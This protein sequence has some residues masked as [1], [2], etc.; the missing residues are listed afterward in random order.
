MTLDQ[1]IDMFFIQSYLL[2]SSEEEI[3]ASI[4]SSKSFLYFL[5]RINKILDNE[6]YFLFFEQNQIIKI[7]RIIEQL[8]FVYSSAGYIRKYH[9]I[10]YHK[11]CAMSYNLKKNSDFIIPNVLT[12]EKALRG[13]PEEI[14]LDINTLNRFNK[15]D[16]SNYTLLLYH[17]ISY[18][19]VD[20]T[21][22]FAT[23][24]KMCSLNPG[25][26]SDPELKLGFTIAMLHFE[27][28]C[29]DSTLYEYAKDTA[30]RVENNKIYKFPKLK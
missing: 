30:R 28:L 7:K 27:N 9:R 26:F 22:F 25:I 4:H 5:D 18:E 2:N 15:I 6:D 12:K 29:D 11:L 21:S 24:N 13:L 17:K 23:V 14:N 16:F 10:V 20:F 19:K 8:T 3:I 1:I